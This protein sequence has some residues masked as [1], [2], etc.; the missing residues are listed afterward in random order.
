LNS[1]LY[2]DLKR[3]G[4]QSSID[5]VA[6]ILAEDALTSA[7]LPISITAR[8]SSIYTYLMNFGAKLALK[9]LREFEITHFSSL[10][11]II[12]FVG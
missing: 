9:I 3:T 7:Y 8:K 1:F 10:N 6:F 11:Q 12:T 2:L 4:R 5:A